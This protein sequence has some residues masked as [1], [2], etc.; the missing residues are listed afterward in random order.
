MRGGVSRGSLRFVA[1]SVEFRL[2]LWWSV[3][4]HGGVVCEVALDGCTTFKCS[5]E[6][7]DAWLR[8][9]DLNPCFVDATDCDFVLLSSFPGAEEG[10]WLTAEGAFL[11]LDGIRL[12]T[13][14]LSL[15]VERTWPLFCS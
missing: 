1:V 10:A 2:V 3:G 11:P 13:E 9:R 8:A 12:P 6:V 4:G 15:P 14:R 5:P 7:V